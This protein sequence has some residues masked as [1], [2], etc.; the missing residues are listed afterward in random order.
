MTFMPL[1]KNEEGRKGRKVV[2][3]YKS[4]LVPEVLT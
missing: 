2:F 3:L 4:F 1:K